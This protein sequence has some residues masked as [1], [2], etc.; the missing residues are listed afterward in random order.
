MI[1]FFGAYFPSWIACSLIGIFGAVIVRLV[2]IKIGLDDVMPVRVIVYLFL[3][4]AIGLA[5]SLIL[6]GR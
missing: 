3:A 5:A 6:F 2:F 4:I 1:P